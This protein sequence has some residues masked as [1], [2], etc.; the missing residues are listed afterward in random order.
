MAFYSWIGGLNF[1]PVSDPFFVGYRSNYFS[2]NKTLEEIIPKLVLVKSKCLEFKSFFCEML[3]NL[4]K[5]IV[6][7]FKR[8][9]AVMEYYDTTVIYMFDRVF[10]TRLFT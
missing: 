7:V 5:Y 8:F 4:G 1:L 6:K 10:K 2:R 9:V 3:Q